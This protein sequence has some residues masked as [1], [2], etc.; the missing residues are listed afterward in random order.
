MF[1]STVLFTLRVMA[2][3]TRSVS[4]TGAALLAAMAVPAAGVVLNSDG[5]ASPDATWIF[6]ADKNLSM[7]Q[8][9]DQAIASL[10]TSY[11]PKALERRRLRGTMGSLVDMEDIPVAQDYVQRVLSTGATVRV[12]SSW[13]NA[14]SVEANASQLA[15]IR[16]LP[17][18][19]Q[20]RPV[21][22]AAP[23][24]SLPAQPVT[25]AASSVTS[26]NGFY[27]SAESQLNQIHIP[28]VHALG[29]TGTGVVIGVLDAGF[30]TTHEAYNEPGH[31]L[32]ILPD[33]TRNFVTW[34][35]V[36]SSPSHGTATLGII[37][38][39]KPNVYVGGAYNASFLL[40]RTEDTSQEVPAEE[41]QWVA[42]LQWMESR[43]AD[44]VSSSLGYLWGSQSQLDGQT[45]VT[46]LA[47]QAACVRG[48]AIVN[49]AG[50]EG[51]DS[52]PLTSHLIAP[53]DANWV[54]S[55]GAVDSNGLI[56]GF[57]S[58][59]PTADGRVKP[60]VLARG[61]A[62]SLLDSTTDTNYWS[63]SGTSFA[64]PL[65]ASAVALMIQ[66]HPD[67]S[68]Q[69]IRDALLRTAS[70]QG[71][72]DPLYINGY[73]IIDVYAAI[74]VPEP[75]TMVLVMAGL[76]VLPFLLRRRGA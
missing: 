21:A 6:F 52:N 4:A 34:G 27:G 37:G 18:V 25:A 71:A 40:A 31:A 32:N 54:I 57:S 23:P 1:C 35:D 7:P 69:E 76:L 29:Y 55:V 58:D 9:Y 42:G 53:A 36:S 72:Y 49:A 56:A 75:A 68:V 13:L 8:G 43:G 15:A 16:A 44:V 11:D 10:Q 39:Y 5:D 2:T 3:L 41:D 28:Q 62:N 45:Y 74:M 66:A 51:H 12:E 65:V 63:G 48:L 24:Q 22:K 46:T 73:G 64:T 30:K 59:G 20:T 26:T 70:G 33:G 17:F 61:V 14:I 47:A 38:G 50:N 67:W 60:E 19:T